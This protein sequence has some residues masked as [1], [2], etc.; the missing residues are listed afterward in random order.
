MSNY[1][2][3]LKLSKQSPSNRWIVK[4]D[5]KKLVREVKLIFNPKEYREM[6]GAKRLYTRKTLLKILE[7]DKKNRTPE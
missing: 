3:H 2:T 4:F 6:K 7:N 5:E 1:I